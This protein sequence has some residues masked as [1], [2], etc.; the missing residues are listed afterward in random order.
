MIKTFT[1]ND[2]IRFLYH[3]TSE[4]EEREINKALICDSVLQTQ[5]KELRASMN[6]LNDAQMQPSSATILS[7]LN[8]S[9]GMQEH[10]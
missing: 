1:Q 10:S 3:E 2:L 8:Y 4:Q 9:R 6:A 7:I 5:Y